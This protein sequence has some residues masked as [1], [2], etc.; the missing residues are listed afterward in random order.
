MKVEQLQRSFIEYTSGRYNEEFLDETAQLSNTNT[1]QLHNPR[2]LL[3]LQ[4]PFSTHGGGGDK[5]A[6]WTLHFGG[7]GPD[8]MSWD[9]GSSS[10]STGLTKE[11][12]DGEV[13]GKKVGALDPTHTQTR[14]RRPA[15]SDARWTDDELVRMRE[16]EAANCWGKEFVDSWDNKMYETAMLMKQVREP[17]VPG[18]HT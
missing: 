8:L 4:K 9:E 16:L 14:S 17:G 2:S 7:T 18:G 11:H 10:W 1:A 5:E 15:Y 3:T 12:F 13:V 6:D